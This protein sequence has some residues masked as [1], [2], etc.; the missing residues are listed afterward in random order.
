MHRVQRPVLPTGG[1]HGALP[2]VSRGQPAG[3]LGREAL[4]GPGVLTVRQKM[5]CFMIVYLSL[6]RRLVSDKMPVVVMVL[7][8][9]VLFLVAVFHVV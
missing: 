8:M 2:R 5:F 3:V 6:I 4:G 9:M 7:F 1:G